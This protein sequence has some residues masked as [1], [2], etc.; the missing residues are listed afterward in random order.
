MNFKKM[1][2]FS[3]AFFFVSLF[4]L[5][6]N[7]LSLEPSF[8]FPEYGINL[9]TAPEGF[10]I[11]TQDS[12]ANADEF[13]EMYSDRYDLKTAQ[14][15]MKEYNNLV[16]IISM[17]NNYEVLVTP[18]HL[19]DPLFCE[20]YLD[21]SIDVLFKNYDISGES[22][23]TLQITKR[24]INDIPCLEYSFHS[25]EENIYYHIFFFPT[26]TDDDYYEIGIRLIS[27]GSPITPEMDKLLMSVI[28]KAKLNITSYSAFGIGNVPTVMD[29]PEFGIY[30]V[31]I[32]EG[33]SVFT[34][35]EEYTTP[36]FYDQYGYGFNTIRETFDSNPNRVARIISPDF[37]YEIDIK[38]YPTTV[39]NTVIQK[40]DMEDWAFKWFYRK[41]S[42]TLSDTDISFSKG[43]FY[44]KYGIE[45]SFHRM[46]QDYY[47]HKFAFSTC[48]DGRYY[49]ITYV[50]NGY[51]QPITD[52]ANSMFT[53]NVEN[54]VLDEML[55]SDKEPTFFKSLY[56][57][58]FGR[59]Y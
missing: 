33:Y 19:D 17:Q 43:Y 22:K 31:T 10:A 15:Y 4:S 40:T 59:T 42:L 41:D 35:T 12:S 7:A 13:L 55:E 18:Y 57:F 39:L 51:N 52:E 37:I 3:G 48:V 2:L 21:M 44:G 54:M 28:H 23:K 50:F 9:L 36:D 16:R 24:T 45:S 34:N 5:K 58:L 6:A 47:Y 14:Y 26:H 38:A 30:N 49:N 29:F 8:S 1:L 27:Y 32:P 20:E 11:L 56:A 25:V 46:S 53:D